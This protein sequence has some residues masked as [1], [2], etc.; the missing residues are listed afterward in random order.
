M[1]NEDKI[2]GLTDA[3]IPWQI[4]WLRILIEAAVGI[5]AGSEVPIE[6]P[7]LYPDVP[8]YGNRD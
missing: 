1:A 7:S 5:N 2:G 3:E 6:K 4:S 8:P